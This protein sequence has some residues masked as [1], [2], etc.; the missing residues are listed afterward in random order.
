MIDGVRITKLQ[1]R[2]DERGW[3]A[4]VLRAEDGAPQVFGQIF[5]T[6]AKPGVTK[7]RHYHTRKIEWFCVIQGR[8]CLVLE[9][10]KSGVRE[11]V[12]MGESKMVT[13]KIPPGVG[14]AITNTGSGMMLLLVYVNEVLDPTDPDT[15]P[16]S[17]R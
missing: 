5:V 16:W 13:V 11:E 10:L 17:D 7:G 1:Q 3:L 12:E 14:H 8:G 15:F 4:E 9:D 6:A 2:F